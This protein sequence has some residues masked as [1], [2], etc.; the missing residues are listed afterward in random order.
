MSAVA[1]IMSNE[2]A[3]EN[4]KHLEDAL[5]A[6]Q[7]VN[8]LLDGAEDIKGLYKAVKKFLAVT[9]EVF[10]KYCKEAF[11]YFKE[12]KVALEDETLDSVVGGFSWSG[13]WNKVKKTVAAVA[14]GAVAGAVIGG[15]TGAATGGPIGFVAGAIGGAVIGGVVGGVFGS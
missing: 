7:E 6:D 11:D 10:E 5:T 15:L 9:F 4:V 12:D 3:M 1:D 14:I 8:A 2:K 13:L